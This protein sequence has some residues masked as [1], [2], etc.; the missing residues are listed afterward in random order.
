MLI[1]LLMVANAQRAL[2]IPN[3]N[4]QAQTLNKLSLFPFP[5]PSSHKGFGCVK[6]T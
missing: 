1:M 6:K 2:K 3:N 4:F 5:M